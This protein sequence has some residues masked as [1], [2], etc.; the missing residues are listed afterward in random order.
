MT[1]LY[2]TRHG[3]TFWNKERRMQG[4]SNSDLTPLGEK[5][6]VALGKRMKDIE[7]DGIYSSS[8]PRALQTALLIRGNRPLD[9]IQEDDLREMYLGSW[10]GRLTSEVEME[11]PEMTDN[12]WHH[13]EKYIRDDAESYLQL[14][15]RAGKKIE[16]IAAGNKNKSI[17]VVTHGVVMKA[18]RSYFQNQPISEIANYPKSPMSTSLSIVEKRD[19]A[20]NILQW[21]DTAHYELIEE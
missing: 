7:L 18:L 2:I 10:Q 6:A 11:D 8:A 21:N 15:E 1:R 16:E 17:L 19:G 3:Q 20:W 9:I 5:Q 12:F 14:K 13:P 4:Q